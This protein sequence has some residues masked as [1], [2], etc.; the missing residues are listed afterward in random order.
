MQRTIIFILFNLLLTVTGFSQNT[1]HMTSGQ[2]LDK[3]QTIVKPGGTLIMQ[4]N[5][6]LV[7]YAGGQPKWQTNTAGKTVT[8]AIMQ[9]DGNFVLYN[10]TSPVWSSNSWNTGASGGY[11]EIDLNT[12]K[13]A[14]YKA[15]GTVAKVLQQGV[16]TPPPPPPGPDPS[17]SPT[18]S[19]PTPV[20]GGSN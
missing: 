7:L 2:R 3:N 13:V 8:H 11:F 4:P 12:F 9:P 10:N 6:N 20:G 19:G 16:G 1:L 18:P 15:N 5:G 14:I 17:P